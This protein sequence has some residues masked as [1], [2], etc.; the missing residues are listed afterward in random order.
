MLM[1]NIWMAICLSVILS[2]WLTELTSC[3]ILQLLLLLPCL[4]IHSSM[5]L[6][7]GSHDLNFC[8]H[9]THTDLLWQYTSCDGRLGSRLW[10]LLIVVDFTWV[11][12]IGSTRGGHPSMSCWVIGFWSHISRKICVS[13]LRHLVLVVLVVIHLNVYCSVRVLIW[14]YITV[15]RAC[16][17]YW[18]LV[19]NRVGCCSRAICVHTIIRVRC[20]ID[21]SSVIGRSD[22]A[23]SLRCGFD[24]VRHGTLTWHKWFVFHLHASV[25]RRVV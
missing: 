12:I 22:A 15:S 18:I 1:L 21:S 17:R 5:I 4:R 7:L 13:A 9:K 3:I 20:V 23:I 6:K 2:L 25:K 19:E 24:Y 10:I 8:I 11:S 16:K 14:C